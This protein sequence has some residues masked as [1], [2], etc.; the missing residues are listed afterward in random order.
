MNSYSDWIKTLHKTYGSLTKE[1]KLSTKQVTPK[2][3]D[4]VFLPKPKFDYTEFVLT[5]ET[6][7]EILKNYE[8]Y[9]KVGILSYAHYTDPAVD[10][11][12]GDYSQE[13]LLC[14]CSTLYP[15]LEQYEE[16]YEEHR[17]YPN[18]DL[19]TSDCLFVDKCFFT[20][21]EDSKFLNKEASVLSMSAPTL[22]PDN[23]EFFELTLLMR[24]RDVL[25][26]F[27]KYGCETLIIGDYKLKSSRIM[28]HWR[29]V[30]D[31]HDGVFKTVYIIQN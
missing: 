10:W 19:F 25:K 3:I 9:G 31:T 1:S 28:E 7:I 6:P 27:A 22:T 20:E 8:L 29:T 12:V 16:F 5:S 24:V 18:N 11:K 4:E 21:E 17:A 14:S 26:V 13:A 2:E 23:E 30:L 15:C